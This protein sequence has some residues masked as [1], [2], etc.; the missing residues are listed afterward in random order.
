MLMVLTGFPGFASA[1]GVAAGKPVAVTVDNFP[2]AESDM[3]GWNCT[4][5][6]Y[7]PR[8]QILDGAGGFPRQPVG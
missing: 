8:A 1:Q 7:R 5:R 2:R 3:P 4:V 6:L